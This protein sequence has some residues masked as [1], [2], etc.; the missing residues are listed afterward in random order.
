MK[1]LWIV[2]EGSP[3]HISQSVGLADAL[4]AVVPVQVVTV[5]GRAKIRG[6]L[7]P[8][9]R[10]IMGPTGRPLPDRLLRWVA[11]IEIPPDSPKPDMII[12]SGG[13]SVFAART[14]AGKYNA[15]YVYIGERKPF[16]AAWFHTVI[17]PVPGE[18]SSNSIDVELI[19]TP[20]TPEL[21]ARKGE[22]EP[23]VWCMI[24]GGAS[25]S[26]CFEE[27]DW[28]GLAEGMNAL[29]EREKIKWLLTTSRR[30]G[31]VAEAI[32][33]KHL[34]PDILEDA[35]W[36][37]EQPRKELHAFMARSEVLF[38]TQDSVTMVTEAVSAGKPVVVI[39]PEKVVFPTESFM[40]NYLNR[41]EENG[42]IVRCITLQVKSVSPLNTGFQL[43]NGTVDN[44]IVSGLLKRLKT[45]WIQND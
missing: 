5:K 31:A 38:V 7:R 20:V 44:S 32:L 16:P 15:P 9:V 8:L 37:A 39:A 33:K 6:W 27:K 30:T 41:L 1:T 21:I 19:P 23:G 40:T 36:W 14:L 17:S 28:V 24:I 22:V 45:F 13:K 43:L 26:H 12:S 4:S 2:S 34:N 42:R 25:R 10:R 3:G 18:S 35:I 11:E 29:A